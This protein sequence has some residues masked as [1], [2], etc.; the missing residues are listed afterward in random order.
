LHRAHL[1]SP[2]S[3]ASAAFAPILRG[4][5]LTGLLACA[6]QPAASHVKIDAFATKGD[7]RWALKRGLWF[8]LVLAAIWAIW[9][10]ASMSMQGRGVLHGESARYITH[11]TDTSKTAGERI[12]DTGQTDGGRYQAR[13]FSYA[14]DLLDFNF[15]VWSS[16]LFGL[17]FHP[18]LHYLLALLICAMLAYAL[19]ESKAA[20]LSLCAAT[21][22]S[23]PFFIVTGVF[24]SAKIMAAFFLCATL[25]LIWAHARRGIAALP[26]FLRA[27]HGNAAL[28]VFA[29]ATLM[30][31]SD[32][33]GFAYILILTV[34]VICWLVISR[35]K[36]GI[37]LAGGLVSAAVLC[38]A[39]N[40]LI[41][42]GI[43]S[44]V[45]GGRPS[46]DCQNV[47]YAKALLN[48][49]SLLTGLR[50]TLECAGYLAGDSGLAGGALLICA[51]AAAPVFS[52]KA[53][54]DTRL[55][56]AAAILGGTAATIA[57]NAVLQTQHPHVGTADA[58]LAYYSVPQVVFMAL[59][60]FM[61]LECAPGFRPVAAALLALCAASNMVFSGVNAQKAANSSY[62]PYF[63][64][65]TRL[66]LR[67][68]KG[69]K[70]S[71][72]AGAADYEA[73]CNFLREKKNITR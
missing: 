20:A 30:G 6:P 4:L 67:C 63:T 57:L 24:R 46:L 52:A 41:G 42:P 34:I 18:A 45:T 16:R 56:A 66:L 33:Q 10:M 32:R 39:Y 40:R 9:C 43:I 15:T 5:R 58:M 49:E 48:P 3:A 51:C 54:K 35:R 8:P 64:E 36:D 38:E 22:L 68:V 2:Y 13:E 62:Q 14:A 17:H 70:V 1:K 65:N 21:L 19:R 11:Y 47:G 72:P 31:L 25:L 61:A 26:R 29:A 50:M 73:A 12:F 7:F 28:P 23:P 44:W 69:E 37:P 27:N 60:V 59:C 71:F 53:E 55:F